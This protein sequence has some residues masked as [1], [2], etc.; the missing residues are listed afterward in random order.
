MDYKNL[1]ARIKTLRT[2]KNMTQEQLADKTNLSTVH[3]SHVETGHTKPSLE[4]VINICNFG[5]GLRV[6]AYVC[7]YGIGGE[8]LYRRNGNACAGAHDCNR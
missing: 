8:Q 5:N 4:T 7:G 3:I 2:N 1:G 6:V